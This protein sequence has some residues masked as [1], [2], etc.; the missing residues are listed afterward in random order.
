MAAKKPPATL[1]V[2]FHV[3]FRKNK[4]TRKAEPVLVGLWVE[5]FGWVLGGGPQGQLYFKATVA[6][7][8]AALKGTERQGVPDRVDPALLRKFTALVEAFDFHKNGGR[9]YPVRRERE[10]GDA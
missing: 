6:L 3:D 9:G 5:T 1:E 7:D 2:G 8:P 4:K 10:E